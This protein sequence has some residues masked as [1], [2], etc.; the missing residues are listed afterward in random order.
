MVTQKKFW[1]ISAVSAFILLTAVPFSTFKQPV[2]PITAQAE[3]TTGKYLDILEYRVIDQEFYS[4]AEIIK[5]DENY[6]GNLVIPA[7]IGDAPVSVI[8]EGAF[9]DCKYIKAVD[10]PRTTDHIQQNAFTNC[11]SLETVIIRS[12]LC[13]IYDSPETFC[14][15]M[16]AH[17]PEM[18][19]FGTIY[20]QPDSPAQK[21]AERYSYDFSDE[22]PEYIDSGID[23][24]TYLTYEVNEYEAVIKSCDPAAV[25]N[26][27]IPNIIEGIPVMQIQEGAFKGCKN[28]THVTLPKYLQEIQREAFAECPSLINVKFNENLRFI[29]DYAFMNCESLIGA[30]LPP[31]IEYL[32]D[33]VFSYC[34][35]LKNVTLSKNMSSISNWVFSDCPQLETVILPE[36]LKYIGEGVFSNC[37]SLRWLEIPETVTTIKNHAFS[38]SL[39]LDLKRE[40]NP[41]VTINGMLID[42]VTAK[43]DITIPDGVHT[44]KERAFYN[45]K[46]IT[47]V[48]IP[49]SVVTIEQHAFGYCSAL[50]TVNIPGKVTKLESNILYGT[51][52][53]EIV[54]PENVKIISSSVLSNCKNL[55]K[56][57]VMNPECDI[58]MSDNTF[59]HGRN[60]EDKFYYSGIICGHENSTAQAYA[61]KFGCTFESLGKA[62]EALKGDVNGDGKLSIAD[63]VELQKWLLGDNL[64]INAENSDLNNDSMIDTF[65]FCLLRKELINS[66]FFDK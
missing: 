26:I 22:M 14:N 6:S 33:S 12:E 56:V 11:A 60:D 29:S 8:C 43:G 34:H 59:C 18:R 21:Y 62:A 32:G 4:F 25:G 54:I 52:I 40:E 46:D 36:N 64:T 10:I 35:S 16:D 31:N 30:E 53:R 3:E 7:F 2:I 20:A 63:A 38:D 47:S 17:F 66:G 65:D 5:C 55:Q 27:V 1:I 42:G 44:I 57:T 49:E 51:G 48:K 23:P 58:Y 13:E 37:T 41:I 24:L 50:E 61:D 45:N 9:Q 28:I 15:S 39:W 19:F